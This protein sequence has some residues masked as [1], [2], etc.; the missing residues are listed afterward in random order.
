MNK[1][2]EELR[3]LAYE[4]GCCRCQYWKDKKCNNGYECVWL[5]IEKELKALEII[6]E[7][8]VSIYWVKNSCCV[9]EYNYENYNQRPTLEKWEFDLLK[10]VLQ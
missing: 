1:G 7:K 6:K 2:L 4:N 8:N 9:D 10:E 3:R 5:D